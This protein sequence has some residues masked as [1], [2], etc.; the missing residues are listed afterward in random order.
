MEKL[1]DHASA[2]IIIIRLP[3]VAD[4]IPRHVSKQQS[5]SRNRPCPAAK[6]LVILPEEGTER[7]V[8]YRRGP[9][10][11]TFS[12]CIICQLITAV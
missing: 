9:Q 4:R 10:K 6:W 7:Q 11:S 2:S 1:A 3:I 12:F 8:P 5:F